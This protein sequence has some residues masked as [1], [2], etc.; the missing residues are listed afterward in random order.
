MLAL[1]ARRHAAVAA[2]IILVG[3]AC[4]RGSGISPAIRELVRESKTGTMQLADATPFTWDQV[5]LFDP[6]T[7][8]SEVCRAL[9]IQA[10]ECVRLV[11]FES[12][13]DGEMSIA[14]LQHGQ[15]IHYTAHSRSN[16]D[17]APAPAAQPLSAKSAVFRIV[18]EETAGERRF[19]LR[20]V[21]S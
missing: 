3:S 1:K 17:F 7:P 20:L 2:A 6:Y 21:E 8:R 4:S 19:L 14:F 11:P 12:T 18:R 13:D 16:G 5:Y 10:D 9:R 15:L